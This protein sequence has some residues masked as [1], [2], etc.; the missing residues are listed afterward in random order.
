M[1]IIRDIDLEDFNDKIDDI[2]K[3]IKKRSWDLIEPTGDYKMK[4]I[5]IVLDFVK[6]KKRKI[7]GSYSH[8]KTIINKN[9]KDS[10]LDDLDIPDI[11]FYSPEPIDDLLNLCN[12]FFDMGFEDVVGRE[13]QHE[14]TYK[15]LRAKNEEVENLC[16]N[17]RYA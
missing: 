3:E 15:I 2:Q 14:E 8:N 7:Y 13:A 16:L 17:S 10:F 1:N 6:N 4:I 11:D 9:K 5:N 12:M